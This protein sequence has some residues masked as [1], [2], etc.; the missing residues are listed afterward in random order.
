MCESKTNMFTAV[1]TII[2]NEKEKL[3]SDDSKRLCASIYSCKT[4]N[5]ETNSVFSDKL[6]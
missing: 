4:A 1:L 6:E 2:D 5:I 3:S